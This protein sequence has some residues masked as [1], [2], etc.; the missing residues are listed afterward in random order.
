[1]SPS[2]GY[3]SGCQQELSPEMLRMACLS[4]GGTELKTIGIH[5]VFFLSRREWFRRVS[6]LFRPRAYQT[7]R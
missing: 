2:F 4:A 1:M 3:V 7:M 6:G 5:P